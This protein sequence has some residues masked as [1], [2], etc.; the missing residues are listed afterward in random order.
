MLNRNLISVKSALVESD[1]SFTPEVY[2]PHISIIKSAHWFALRLAL[3]VFPVY[4]PVFD[5]A[6][7]CVGCTCEFWRRS[8]ECKRKSPRLYLPP[9]QQC[10][11]PGK[12]PLVS[13][14]KATT[15]P[16][17]IDR[18]FRSWRAGDVEYTPNIGINTN[19]SDLLVLDIDRRSGGNVADVLRIAD[20]Q[21]VTVLSGSGDGSTH[22]YYRRGGLAYGGHLDGSLHG[23][24]IKGAGA[25]DYVVCPPSLHKSGRRYSFEP[26]YGPHE[27]DIMAIPPALH[28]ILDRATTRRTPPPGAQQTPAVG[29]LQPGDQWIINAIKRSATLNAL[30][31]GDLSNTRSEAVWMLCKLLAKWRCDADQIERVLRASALNFDGKFDFDR[32]GRPWLRGRIENAILEQK[33]D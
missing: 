25:G 15:D 18:W 2:Q 23:I 19:L 33:H 26:G 28:E 9:G 10:R 30:F 6:G 7:V 31:T 32:K 17:T 22:L 4:A 20:Q 27:I 13:P 16:A 3:H 21:T 5:A 11:S 29:E 14:A 24:D 8:E 1:K 12:C